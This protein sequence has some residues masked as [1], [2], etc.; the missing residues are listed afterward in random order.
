MNW[1]HQI[2]LNVVISNPV[3]LQLQLLL[4]LLL[5]LLVPTKYE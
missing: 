5:L 2:P 3:Q 1:Y 4:L